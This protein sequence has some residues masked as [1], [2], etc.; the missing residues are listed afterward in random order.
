MEKAYEEMYYFWKYKI[1]DEYNSSQGTE[2]Y[3]AF[4][5]GPVFPYFLEVDFLNYESFSKFINLFGIEGFELFDSRERYSLKE[6]LQKIKQ[7]PHAIKSQYVKNLLKTIK[8]EMVKEQA[9]MYTFGKRFVKDFPQLNNIKELEISEHELIQ[10]AN[11]HLDFKCRIFILPMLITTGSY[12]SA[13]KDQGKETYSYP[14]ILA[15]CY[16]ELIHLIQYEEKILRCKNCQKFFITS[17]SNEYYCD[18]IDPDK[19]EELDKVWMDIR[20][21]HRNLIEKEGEPDGAEWDQILTDE[22]KKRINL[23]TC[24]KVG[25]QK[26]WKE[27]LTLEQREFVKKKKRWFSKLYY[28]K[29]KHRDEEYRQAKEEFEQWLKKNEPK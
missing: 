7:K 24:K 29:E 10:N 25:S 28:L 22:E 20:K 12:V 1:E 15:R 21:A 27:S 3:I 9:L 18:R 11:K 6:E 23:L 17:K 16:R 26:K 5:D 14:S 4:N 19:M 8:K 13:I 2:P